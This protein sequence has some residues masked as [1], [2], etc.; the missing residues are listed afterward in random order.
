MQKLKIEYLIK[1]NWQDINSIL[2]YQSF[3]YIL[4]AIQIKLINKYYNNLLIGYFDIKK[5]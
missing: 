3:P 1:N 4:E 2:Y 5:I